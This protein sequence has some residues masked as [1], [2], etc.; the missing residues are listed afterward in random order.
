MRYYE[1]NTEHWSDCSIY[2]PPAYE[3]GPCDCGPKVKVLINGTPIEQYGIEQSL[4]RIEKLLEKIA[5]YTEP[6]KRR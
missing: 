5:E 1:E 3:P 2:N 4:M 6:I